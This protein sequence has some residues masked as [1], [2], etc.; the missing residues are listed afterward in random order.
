MSLPVENEAQIENFNFRTLYQEMFQAKQAGNTQLADRL[1][2]QMEV[3]RSQEYS[4]PSEDKISEISHT[5]PTFALNVLG[6]SQSELGLAERSNC[7]N[8]AFNFHSLQ[9]RY[10]PY[11]T[12]EFLNKIQ[13]EFQQKPNDS[14]FRFGDLVVIWSRTIGTW[15]HRSIDV[16]MINKADADFPYGLV[17]DHVVVRL[18]EELVFHKPDPTLESRYQIDFL[19]SVVRPNIPNRGFELTFHHCKIP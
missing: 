17:F 12:M 11:S 18:S 7:I 14:Q 5:L 6:K 13:K 8:A 4:V 19:D 10:S 9:P 16:H 3:L 2:V 15:D 1:M